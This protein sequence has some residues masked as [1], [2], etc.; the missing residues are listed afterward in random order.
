MVFGNWLEG[1]AQ[2]I[3]LVRDK[4]PS[5]ADLCDEHVGSMYATQ[6]DAG[7]N[8]TPGTH[9]EFPVRPRSADGWRN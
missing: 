7:E 5:F 6:R 2:W 9:A 3:M 8:P 1:Q 4:R